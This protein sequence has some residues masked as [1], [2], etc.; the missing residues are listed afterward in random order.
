MVRTRAS[1]KGQAAAVRRNFDESMELTFDCFGDFWMLAFLGSY[2][3]VVRD[4]PLA[5]S[6]EDMTGFFR[7]KI[8]RWAAT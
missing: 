7:E 6:T 2:E 1:R 4:G 3:S 8:Q 5:K